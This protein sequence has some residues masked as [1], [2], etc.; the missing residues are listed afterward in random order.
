MNETTDTSPKPNAALIDPQTRRGDPQTPV[1]QSIT[2]AQVARMLEIVQRYQQEQCEAILS[3]A[4]LEADS[5]RR[6]AYTEARRRLRQDVIQ[7]RENLQRETAALK[8]K[9][10]T[11]D[12]RR[13][14]ALEKQYLQQA[15][16]LLEQQLMQRWRQTDLRQDWL[17]CL[18]AAATEALPKGAWSIEH[19]VDWPAEEQNSFAQRVRSLTGQ[20]AS[21]IPSDSLTAGVLLRFAGVSV[22]GT[23]AGLLAQRSRIEAEFL[24][25]CPR[26]VA[27]SDD[28]EIDST[29]D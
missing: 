28:R 8:A 14:H 10:Q 21:L 11:Q 20:A 17:Q 7:S 23:V 3:Q 24:A 27:Q 5:V 18:L 12:K 22:D 13:R 15:W 29:S 26:C 1:P 2:E 16:Q 6:Q 25:H 19:P 4:Q 9:Q